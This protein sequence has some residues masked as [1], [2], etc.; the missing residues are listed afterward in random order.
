MNAKRILS[1]G[2]CAMDHGTIRH[3]LRSHIDDVDVLEASSEADA[4]AILTAKPCDL[5]L[6]NRVLDRDRSSGLDIIRRLKADGRFADL[7][8]MMVSNYAD[9]QT[10]AEAAGALPGFGKS[11]LDDEARERVLEALGHRAG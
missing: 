7:P 4:L 10:K 9:A 2:Q 1:V 5:V 3:F 6:V 11:E 8:V